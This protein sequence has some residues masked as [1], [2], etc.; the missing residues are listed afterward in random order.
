MNRKVIIGTR[1]S[2]LALWQANHVRSLLESHFPDTDFE[3][4]I[5]HTTGD[6]VLDVA[7]SKI[8]DKGLF[9][10]QI[11][12]ELLDGG[13]DLAVHSLKDLQ[14][15]QPEGLKIGA[16]CER[17]NSSDVF[18][19]R[20]GSPIEELPQ[21]ARVAT[22][23][24]RRRS[25]L[26]SFRPDLVI[27][28]IRG[29]VPTRLRKFD[30]SDLDGMI[31]AY[32]GLHRLGFG[33]RITQLIPTEIMLPAVGQGAVAIEVRKGNDEVNA[34]VAKLDHTETRICVSAE[35]AFL[36]RLEGGCQVPIG[37]AAVVNGEIVTL[38]GFVG[39]LD[40]KASFRES[41]AGS[42][43]SSEDLGVGLADKLI[44][45]GARELLDDART[46]AKAATE[47]PV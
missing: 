47:T 26:L 6:K 39:S 9:T 22:G 34:M 21:G 46:E 11:E 35:R 5:I 41:M 12:S 28:E 15:S 4:K 43:D 24:L 18:I 20:T 40:G 3:I 38:T 32:A 42:I 13:I 14:T 33:D 44:R 2:D 36:K 7:L 1:G 17:E 29:N 30:E 37:A 45:L 31:L 16:V 10:R 27:E 23:S 8:G 25:Q 19:S